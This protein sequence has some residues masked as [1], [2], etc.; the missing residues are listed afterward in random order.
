MEPRAHIHT[1]ART[2]ADAVAFPNVCAV[3][4]SDARAHADD[5]RDRR[6]P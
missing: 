6:A 5:F 3:P 1:N 4:N 2:V